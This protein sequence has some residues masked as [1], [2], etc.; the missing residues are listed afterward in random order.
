M[1]VD[2]VQ[3]VKDQLDA[4]LALDPTLTDAIITRQVEAQMELQ[5]YGAATITEQQKVYISVLATQA[6]IPRL[7]LTFSQAK[8]LK[9]AK[10]GASE[11]E[12][13]AAIEFLKALQEQLKNQVK[14]AAKEAAPE[15]LDRPLPPGYPKPRIVRID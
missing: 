1:A 11:A 14:L 2:A 10:G 12:Y 3:L 8:R 7:L 5:Q 6:L 13:E 15:D 9:R 4:V